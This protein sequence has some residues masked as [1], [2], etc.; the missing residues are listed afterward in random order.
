MSRGFQQGKAS[1][2]AKIQAPFVAPVTLRLLTDGGAM[3]SVQPFQNLIGI[4]TSVSV[5]LAR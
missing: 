5:L 2:L 1:N 4:L 3:L